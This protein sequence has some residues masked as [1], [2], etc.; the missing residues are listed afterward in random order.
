MFL[1]SIVINHEGKN[2]PVRQSVTTRLEDI[3]PA[4]ES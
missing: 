2:L 3:V 4:P 1:G